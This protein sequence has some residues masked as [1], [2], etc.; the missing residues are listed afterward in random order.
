MNMKVKDPYLKPVI[1]GGLLITMLSVIFAPAIFLWSII[2]GYLAVRIANKIT[3]EIPSIIDGLFLGLFSGII[4]G[5]CLDILTLAFFSSSDNQH[6]LIRTLEKNWPKK[7]DPLPNFSE[8]LPALFLTTSVFMIIITVLFAIVGGY[9]GVL[10][11]R[12]KN[13]IIK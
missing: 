9:I 5:T 6:L 13:K 12:H 1:F 10:I 7:A 11:S 4:G 8:L 3:K 2:G